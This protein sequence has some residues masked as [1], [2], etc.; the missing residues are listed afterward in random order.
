MTIVK[1]SATF[2]RRITVDAALALGHFKVETSIQDSLSYD[3]ERIVNSCLF[4]FNDQ[5][6]IGAI[7]SH[8]YF[9]YHIAL[10]MLNKIYFL[11]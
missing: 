7:E 3:Q 8:S 11:A 5:L 9:H 4:L 6:I 2:V 1:D 10:S